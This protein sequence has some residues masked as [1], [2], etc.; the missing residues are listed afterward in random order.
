MCL[1]LSRLEAD[2]VRCHSLLL[3]IL[4][5]EP[6]SFSLNSPLVSCLVSEPQGS[7]CLQLPPWSWDYNSALNHLPSSS[8]WLWMK[9]QFHYCRFHFLS[10]WPTISWDFLCSRHAFFF[11]SKFLSP[12]YILDCFFFYAPF[13]DK[14]S[15]EQ[16][17]EVTC[18]G[19]QNQYLSKSYT[20]GF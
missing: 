19:T 15:R 8:K 17:N 13:T 4:V 14:G 1:C 16:G 20:N 11:L 5:L 3:S 18:L 7:S 2:D 10:C 6:G 12:N 9:I